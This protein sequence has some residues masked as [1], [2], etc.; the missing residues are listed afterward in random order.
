[1]ILYFVI[2]T[3]VI[4]ICICALLANDV[5][6]KNSAT[7]LLDA[8]TLCRHGSTLCMARAGN[9]YAPWRKVWSA[10]KSSGASSKQFS[11]R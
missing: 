4:C 11:I 3:P 9:V 6:R 8:Y 7:M 5:V 1:M 10:S 2:L